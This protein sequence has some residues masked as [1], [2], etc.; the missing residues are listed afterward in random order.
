MKKLAILYTRTS[1]DKQDNSILVQNEKNATYVQ[2]KDLLTLPELTMDDPDVSGAVYAFPDRPNGKRA[3]EILRNG[4]SPAMLSDESRQ[5][6]EGDGY[7]T[8]ALTVPVRSI[9]FSKVDRMGRRAKDQLELVD[10][11][12]KNSFDLH[13]VDFFGKSVAVDDPATQMMFGM[14]A[15]L[16]QW[17]AD[18]IRSRINETFSSKRARGELCSNPAYGEIGIPSGRLS[19][20]GK[21]IL[22]SA[23]HPDE[24]EWLRR[25]DA[26][27]KAGHSYQA[28]AKKLNAFGV[29]TKNPAGALIGKR[30]GGR[31][32]ASG[33][34]SCGSV[35]H[36]LTSRYAQTALAEPAINQ[37]PPE[38]DQPETLDIAQAA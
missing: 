3:V 21:E 31:A 1:T 38:T 17:E 28:I 16:A 11:A 37:K 34:W 32:A 33:Q 29:P 6:L 19:K 20:R 15:V 4:L 24:L 2:S 7:N 26:W 35:A 22:L 9:V 13:V 30:G 10:W 8:S 23:P 5:I 18:T 25:M 36:A 27:R 12:K 14:L